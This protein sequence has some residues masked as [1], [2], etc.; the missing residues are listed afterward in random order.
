LAVWNRAL[1]YEEVQEAFGHPPPSV[2]IG[3][4]NG[5]DRDLRIETEAGAEYHFGDPWHAMPRAVTASRPDV[6]LKIPLTGLQ[7][8]LNHVFHLKTYNSDGGK[9]ARLLLSVNGQAHAVREILRAYPGQDLFWPV[10]KERLADGTNTF[11]L[12]YVDGPAA[13]ITF[14]WL[15]I[16][17]A[18]QV[19]LEDNRADTD[20]I[21]EAPQ[22]RTYWVTD[23]D[24]KHLARAVTFVQTNILIHF[25][26]S[27]QMVEN[28]D[29]AYTTRIVSQGRSAGTEP[30]P[31]YPFSIG[32]NGRVLYRSETGVPDNTLVTVPFTAGDL[33]GGDNAVNLMF[34]GSNGWLQFDFHRL[35]T[36]PW[37]L[38]DLTGTLFFMR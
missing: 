28:A 35:D 22:Y 20:F 11:T 17:G 32:V 33:R 34:D 29:F 38:P 2:R 24:W 31:P 13:W 15:E 8:G 25:N 19:G 16:G 12:S 7:A 5:N 3:L 23:P 10:S 9:P 27:S 18:W 30:V 37:I 21:Q 4:D 14:D 1:S 36:V 26:L 6:T